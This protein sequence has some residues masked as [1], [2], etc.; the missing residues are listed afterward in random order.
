MRDSARTKY[1]FV[2]VDMGDNDNNNN[3]TI[4]G[5]RDDE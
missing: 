4:T 5:L 1:T 2:K 3:K